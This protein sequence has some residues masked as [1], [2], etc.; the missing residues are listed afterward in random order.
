[1]EMTFLMRT[2]FLYSAIGSTETPNTTLVF[3]DYYLVTESGEVFSHQRREKI[4]RKNHL[5]DVP[6]NG[7]CTMIRTETLRSLGGYREDLGAQDGFDLWSK[8][9]DH[10]K[11]CKHKP[12][13]LL[14]I[15]DTEGT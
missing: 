14:S 4:T 6:A 15:A 3:P 1:M 8:I 10:R 5:L 12:P 13:P 7:A 2:F 11:V 9:L